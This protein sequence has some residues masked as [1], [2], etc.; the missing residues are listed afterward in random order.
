MSIFSF[1]KKKVLRDPPVKGETWRM[2]PVHVDPW[3][4][5]K[6]AEVTIIDQ[7]EGWVRYK[8]SDHIFNDERMLLRTFM[9]IYKRVP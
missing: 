4:P 3:T 9:D 7:K 2:V 5:K 6:M 1:F 8:F